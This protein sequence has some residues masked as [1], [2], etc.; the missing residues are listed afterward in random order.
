MLASIHHLEPRM[1]RRNQLSPAVAE[2][3]ITH[4]RVKVQVEVASCQ[5]ADESPF[6]R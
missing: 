1:L 2:A 5:G 4:S 3:F 6:G